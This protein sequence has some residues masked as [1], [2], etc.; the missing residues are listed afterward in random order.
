M[1]QYLTEKNF[2]SFYKNQEK[3]I[4]ILNHRMTGLERN[5]FGIK[6]DICWLK[7]LLFVVTGL[8]SAILVSVLLKGIMI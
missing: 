4:D 6:T 1:G 2:K 5:V 8:L 3:L 7:K